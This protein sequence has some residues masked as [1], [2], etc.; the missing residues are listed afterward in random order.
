MQQTNI[1]Q[2]FE[3]LIK[4]FRHYLEQNPTEYLYFETEY[5]DLFVNSYKRDQQKEIYTPPLVPL[6]KS[7]SMP[8]Q[9]IDKIATQPIQAQ[10]TTKE[11]PKSLVK[12]E[13]PK[14]P[15]PRASSIKSQSIKIENKAQLQSNYLQKMEP[16]FAQILP[17]IPL[18]R[19]QPDDHLAKKVAQRWKYEKQAAEISI[20]TTT[21]SKKEKA[22][23]SNLAIALSRQ[24]A[25][26]RVI[27]ST[28]LEK[29][30]EWEAFLS[31][32]QLQIILANDHELW[33]MK[34]LMQYYKENPSTRKA[35]LGKTPLFMLP[36]LSLYFKDPQLKR[37][38]W[39][40]LCQRIETLDL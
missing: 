40:A 27:D 35:Y 36:D 11:K 39:K 8:P 14:P 20:L 26:A 34:K 17:E 29:A 19:S 13:E 1:S 18:S 2:S 9:K 28:Q 5:R 30:D 37:S 24:W 33:R 6:I 38:L 10:S 12:K 16:I 15:P 21:Q 31:A 32:A 7:S 3:S 22:F 23:L 4:E 25:P